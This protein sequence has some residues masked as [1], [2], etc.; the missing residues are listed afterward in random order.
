MPS[1]RSSGGGG[2]DFGWACGGIADAGGGP[3]GGGTKERGFGGTVAHDVPLPGSSPQGGVLISAQ[4]VVLARLPPPAPA[5][6][7]GA[8]FMMN[9][10]CMVQHEQQRQAEVQKA[11]EP[12]L[13]RIRLIMYVHV[14]VC[15]HMPW[16]SCCIA[17]M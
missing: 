2:A 14:C 11:H 5:G 13:L 17:S 12:N 7:A 8:A 16:A 10:D 3:G 1:Q 9:E 4:F 15:V 6:V